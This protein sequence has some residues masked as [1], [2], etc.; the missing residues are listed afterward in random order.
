MTPTIRVIFETSSETACKE[1]LKTGAD[2]SNSEITSPARRV[3]R[4]TASWV[5]PKPHGVDWVVPPCVPDSS[6]L[7]IRSSGHRITSK[8][9][10]VWR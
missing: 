6:A 8:Q 3:F 2:S 5:V 7:C 1:R 4:P 9:R 10:S